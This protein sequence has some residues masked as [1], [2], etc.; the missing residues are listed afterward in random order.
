MCFLFSFSKLSSS[1]TILFKLSPTTFPLSFF[2]MFLLSRN[3]SFSL[4]LSHLLSLSLS[5]NCFFSGIL[6]GDVLYYFCSLFLFFLFYSR[7]SSLVISF[8]SRFLPFYFVFFLPSS[9]FLPPF[10]Y[11]FL[12]FSSFKIF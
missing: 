12:F 5:T 7:L 6:C 11:L 1:V 10:S 4:F 2:L 8:I 3:F 9:F